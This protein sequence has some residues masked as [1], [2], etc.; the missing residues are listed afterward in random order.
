MSPLSPE[1]GPTMFPSVIALLGFGLWLSQWI[2]AQEG[3][4][5]SPTLQADPGPLIPLKK[6]VTLRCQGFPGADRYR[7]RKEGSAQ[8]RDVSTTGREAEFPIPSV[9]PNTTGSYYCLY[10]SQSNW[11]QPSEPLRLVMTD[12][13]DKP[14][15]SA[16]PGPEVFLGNNVILRCRSQQ[17][18]EYYVL[19]KEGE[20][21]YMQNEGKWCHADFHLSQVTAADEGSYRCYSFHMDTLS[22][23]SAPSDPLELRIRGLVLYPL[24]HL[25]APSL[26]LFM[27]IRLKH[28]R[29]PEVR[30]IWQPLMTLSFTFPASP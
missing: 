22:E 6:S 13:Y 12:W 4:L 28:P 30:S 8:Y 14:S 5:P 18:F 1:S 23:W 9:V 17:W 29:S 19:H 15:L 16:L 11:S 2:R 24:C 10:K 7:L 20:A 27:L 26:D 25:A 3:T 21:E